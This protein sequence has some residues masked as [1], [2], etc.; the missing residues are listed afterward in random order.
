LKQAPRAW[1]NM[2]TDAL[3]EFG[4]LQSLVDP[5]LFV[6]H[7]GSHHLFLLVYVDDILVTSSHVDLIQ[8]LLHQLKVNFALKD[9]GQLSFFLGIQAS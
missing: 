4:F 3:L 2:L 5:S 6:L 7:Y 9:L 1:F 8:S